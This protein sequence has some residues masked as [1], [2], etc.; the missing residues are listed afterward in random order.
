MSFSGSYFVS[1]CQTVWLFLCISSI[2][3]YLP[4]LKEWPYIGVLWV[5]W[6]LPSGTRARSSAPGV[7]PFVVC[8]RPLWW[9]GYDCSELVLAQ[10]VTWLAEA[11]VNTLERGSSPVPV[12]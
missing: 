9:L 4:V 6:I 5:Q 1:F 8:V 3:C 12:P 10:L 2:S 11:A 7:I